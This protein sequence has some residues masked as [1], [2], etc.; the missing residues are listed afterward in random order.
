LV[1][2]T[3]PYNPNLKRT[4]ANNH[5]AQR[6]SAWLGILSITMAFLGLTSAYLVRKFAGNWYNFEI[7]PAFT[8]STILILVSSITLFVAHKSNQSDNKLA[9]R[10]GL[11]F[12]FILGIVFCI[13]QY[14]GWQQL[15][16]EGI[17]LEGNPSGSFFYVITGMHAVHLVGGLFFML[18]SLL[19]SV[20]VFR[21]KYSTTFIDEYRDKLVIRTDLLSIYWHF[22]G[23]LWLYLFVFLYFN[24]G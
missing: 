9:L 10:L 2:Q 3:I 13:N 20:F 7:P 15:T 1:T 4:E 23:L 24:Q 6:F 8:T 5:K 12:T 11:L 17:Y 18:I 16:Y 14:Q 19:K 21:K 22:M